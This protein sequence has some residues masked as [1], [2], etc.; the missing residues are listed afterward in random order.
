MAKILKYVLGLDGANR[1]ESFYSVGEPA[2]D[3]V[4]Y[5]AV[6]NRDNHVTD[7]EFDVELFLSRWHR[8]PTPAERGCMLSH[9]KMWED[10]VASDADWAL[11]A[12][13]DI[14]IS[15]DA[16]A[17]VNAIITKYPQVQLVNLCDAYSFKAGTMNPRVD[18]IR[19]SLLSPFVHGKYRMGKLYGSTRLGCTGL[20]LI[21]RSG[22]ELLLKQFEN[23]APGTVADD[24]KLY[25]QW[26]V[27]V[28]FVQP[29]LCDWEGSSVIL[30]S[31][32]SHL[33]MLAENQKG[34][35][36]LDRVRIALAPKMRL[37]NAKNALDATLDEVKQRLGKP[38]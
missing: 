9:V 23:K 8:E 32:K 18:Y 6:D 14:L 4:P 36:A 17:V 5:S 12:E 13:D 34:S 7:D 38:K 11:I 24:Y 15:P 37:V 25:Q 31:G 26:G 30:D 35:S 16:E 29:G 28:R 2:K 21:S 10:F 22:A 20:Y 27:D 1:F 19:L 33:E 3:F